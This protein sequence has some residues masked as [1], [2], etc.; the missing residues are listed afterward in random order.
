MLVAYELRKTVD[1]LDHLSGQELVDW[2]GFFKLRAKR[3]DEE[4]KA[5]QRKNRR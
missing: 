1:E 5:S 4:A 2:L 3:M